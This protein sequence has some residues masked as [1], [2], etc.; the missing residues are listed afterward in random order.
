MRGTVSGSDSLSQAGL[1]DLDQLEKR[2]QP[3]LI[4]RARAVDESGDLAGQAL[5]LTGSRLAGCL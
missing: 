4:L 2:G 5:C 3:R 1:K